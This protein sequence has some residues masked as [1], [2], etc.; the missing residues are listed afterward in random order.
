MEPMTRNER[1]KGGTQSPA[2]GQCRSVRGCLEALAGR[3]VLVV[4]VPGRDVPPVA[5][6]LEVPRCIGWSGGIGITAVG[7]YKRWPAGAVARRMRD[8]AAMLQLAA[9]N[10]LKLCKTR[11]SST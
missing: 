9:R 8:R 4:C 7:A 1:R 5:K 10:T 2:S 11:G 6:R 3:L